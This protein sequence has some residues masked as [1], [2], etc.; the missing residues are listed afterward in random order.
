MRNPN[1]PSKSGW[2][3][4]HL[5]ARNGHIEIVKTLIQCTDNPNVPN[6]SGY[7][8]YD[9]A[10]QF[11]HFEIM[12]LFSPLPT[13]CICYGFR[14]PNQHALQCGHIF[15]DNCTRKFIENLNSKFCAVCRAQIFRYVFT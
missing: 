7:T 1:A 5:A 15:C 4:I 6:N 10:Q 12:N 2:T 11:K 3:P 13:C 14:I 8:A 9:L